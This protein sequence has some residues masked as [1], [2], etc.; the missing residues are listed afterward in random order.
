MKWALRNVRELCSDT[1]CQGSGISS[2]IIRACQPSTAMVGSVYN[3]CSQSQEA[4]QNGSLNTP[5]TYC[6]Y[7]TRRSFVILHALTCQVRHITATTKESIK[8]L[9]P[10]GSNNRNNTKRY[11]KPFTLLSYKCNSSEVDYKDIRRNKKVR[12]HISLPASPC[13]FIFCDTVVYFYQTMSIGYR[14]LKKTLVLGSLFF[15][16]AVKPGGNVTT[17][18][19]YG[20]HTHASTACANQQGFTIR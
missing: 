2:S 9:Y 11:A 18:C 5:V 15:N 3:V 14:L 17:I 6:H 10:K 8:H 7:C 16:Q 1:L 20:E 13:F 19:L 4:M 12:D